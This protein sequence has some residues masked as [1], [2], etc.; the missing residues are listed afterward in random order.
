MKKTDKKLKLASVEVVATIDVKENVKIGNGGGG[1]KPSS[2]SENYNKDNSPAFSPAFLVYFGFTLVELLVVIAIIGILI[3]LLLPAVQAAREAAR[4]SQCSNNLKQWALAAHVHADANKGW[5]N[6]AGS[7]NA[8]TLQNGKAYQRLSWP[9]ELWAFI[10]QVPLAEK[11]NYGLPFYQGTNMDTYRVRIPAYYCPSDKPNSVQSSAATI[12]WTVLGNYAVNAG[13][14]HLHISTPESANDTGAPYGIGNVYGLESIIDGTSNTA[15]F[16]EILIL[17]D[18]QTTVAGTT[19]S[20]GNILNDECTPCFMSIL[21]PNSKSPDEVRWCMD[22]TTDPSNSLYKK[23]PC[24]V[25]PN[26]FAV[27][28]AARSNHSGGV[29]VSMCDGG[30]KFITDTI[31]H[32]IWQAGLSAGGRES[33]TLP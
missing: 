8:R 25:A 15:G 2:E 23:Y 13:N 14:M 10:E 26:N 4:R 1:G 28:N 30:V 22:G 5:L 11:Y 32:S 18:K 21:T 17:A 24:S 16:S 7:P 9:T 20:R 29:N 12:Y 3:A 19:D 6:T 27:Q 33:E 31:A